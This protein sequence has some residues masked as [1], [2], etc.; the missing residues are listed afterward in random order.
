M[1]IN[2]LYCEQVYICDNKIV[3]MKLQGITKISCDISLSIIVYIFMKRIKY[4]FKM[5]LLILK[6]IIMCVRCTIGSYLKKKKKSY[7]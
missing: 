4:K 1:H 6:Q 7:V 5:T 2:C 3:Y